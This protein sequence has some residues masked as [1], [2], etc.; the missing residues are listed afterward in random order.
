MRAS[1]FAA[2]GLAAYSVFLVATIPAAYVAAQVNAA[3]PGQVEIGDAEG[4]L[5]RGSARARIAPRRAGKGIDR[6]EW[7][8]LPSHLAAGEIALALHVA[9]EGISAS[10]EAA[11]G[12]SQWRLR[13]A[14]AEGEASALATLIPA[15]APWRPAGRVSLTMPSLTLEGGEVRGGTLEAEWRGAVSGL[16]EVRPLGAYRA[17]WR[18][19]N[20]PGRIVVTTLQG[21]L[22]IT[23]EGTTTPGL[24][25]AF[26]GEARG[27]G[28][29]A[30]ALEPL[31]DLMGPRRPDGAR[32]LQVRLE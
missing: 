31:L 26:S 9:A 24:R 13:D 30:K 6:I 25:I 21:P 14:K 11:R 8:F 19:E 15:I 32:T 20:G 18:A 5:W 10:G 2:L 7:R 22:S 27:E 28:D 3:L 4:T 16:S 1:G 12:F 29:A 23:G 17:T